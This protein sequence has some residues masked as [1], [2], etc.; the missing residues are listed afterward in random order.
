MTQKELREYLKSTGRAIREKE[1]NQTLSYRR[2]LKYF[3]LFSGVPYR[4]SLFD[5]CYDSDYYVVRPLI[6]P[7]T[8]VILVCFSVTDPSR[9]EKVR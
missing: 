7:N 5:T 1:S 3:V 9:F 6:Y 2:S 4:F 8:N